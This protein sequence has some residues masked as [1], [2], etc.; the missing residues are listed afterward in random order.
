MPHLVPHLVQYQ[1]SK[2]RL[3]SQILKYLPQDCTRLIEPFAGSAAV[4]LAAAYHR[5]A[6]YFHL[7]DLNGPLIGILQAVVED[8]ATLCSQYELLWQEQFSYPEH[9]NHY[10]AVRDR[11]NQGEQS[12]ANLLYLLARCVKGAVRYNQ[13]GA[14]NQSPDRRRHGTKPK[15]MSDNVHAISKLLKGRTTF[16]NVD[17]REVLQRATPE[18]I[19]YLDPPYQG[20]SGTKNQRYLA[21]LSYQELVSSLKDLEQRRIG[22]I[23]SYDGSC[24]SRKYGLTLPEELQC[25]RILL[26]AGTSAQSTLLGKQAT[27]FEALYLS[28]HLNKK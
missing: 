4:S 10:Y 13:N 28:P 18:D 2:R 15:I 14:F 20:T 1:G 17:Y 6:K 24:G 22:F 11:F 3:A 26:N 8:P 5:K 7:N 9:T 23:L 27:T 19:V 25:T 16:S 21:G 12:P